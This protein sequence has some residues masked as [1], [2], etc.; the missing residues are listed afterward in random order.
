MKATVQF[1]SQK[2]FMGPPVSFKLNFVSQLRDKLLEAFD[3]LPDD[4]EGVPITSW[5]KID[6]T[7]ER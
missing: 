7:I 3:K 5:T 4:Y 6:I 1:Y 2:G